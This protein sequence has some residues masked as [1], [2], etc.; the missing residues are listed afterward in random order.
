M[1][2]CRYWVPLESPDE[3]GNDVNGDGERQ[4][5]LEDD[6]QCVVYFWQ[7]RDA[8]NMGWLTFTFR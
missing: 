4:P 2:L 6:F 8:G 7:G 5:P 3:D 1:F